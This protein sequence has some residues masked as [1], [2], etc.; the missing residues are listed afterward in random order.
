MDQR[1]DGGQWPQRGQE[2]GPSRRKFLRQVGLTAAATAAVAGAAD[3]F[4]VTAA[5]ASTQKAARTKVSIGKNATPFSKASPATAK[6]VR[7]IRAEYNAA[8]PDAVC[9]WYCHLAPGSC[10]APCHP[11]GVWCHVCV[12]PNSSFSFVCLGGHSNFCA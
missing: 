2:P 5:R 9:S 12:G 10:G 11:N 7:E 3:A 4:G 1:D 8:H 6:K